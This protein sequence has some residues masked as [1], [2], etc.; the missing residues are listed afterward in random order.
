MHLLHQQS[1]NIYL[2][3][4]TQ[5]QKVYSNVDTKLLPIGPIHFVTPF[6]QDVYVAATLVLSVVAIGIR[7][8]LNQ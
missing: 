8:L 6:S 7:F 1:L 2:N 4:F 5:K 3:I